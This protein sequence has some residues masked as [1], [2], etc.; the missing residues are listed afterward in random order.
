MAE[1]VANL[2]R[3]VPEKGLP[4]MKRTKLILVGGFLGT[5]KT[6]LLCQAAHQLTQQGHRVAV[7]T[8]D[9][10]PGLV[11]TLIFKQAGWTVGEIAGGCFCCK[12]DDLVETANDLIQAANPDILIAEPVGSCTDLSATVLQPFKDILAP[13]FEL[14]PFT[15]LIDPNRLLDVIAKSPLSPLHS[16]ARYILR[17]Q[18][19][20]ADILV[21]NKADQ[22]PLPDFQK[23]Q[24]ELGKQFPHTPL[25]SMS[26]LHGQGVPQWLEAVMQP[27]TLVGQKLAEVDYDTYAEGEAVLGWLNVTAS[28]SPRERLDWGS[29]SNGFLE[30]LQRI[31]TNKSAEIAHIKM[32]VISAGNQSLSASLTSSQGKV[33]IR[34]QMYGDS[35]VTLVLNA[36]VQLPSEELLAAIEE[37]LKTACGA[38]IQ[39][40]VS[41]I[42]SLSP[43][44]PQPLHRYAT[45]I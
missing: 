40:R 43:G 42:Q 14:A 23:L 38:I 27:G 36:R 16:S 41:A 32:L 11:D 2:R 25:L 6:T 39:L 4:T 34:G 10:A 18:L 21:L 30:S 45:V 20:E 17:K 15:V 12:F 33:T 8:N 24:D 35:R 5:G 19:E 9:Q 22:L 29:W 26:A 28:A 3:I 13:Q 37:H 1:V 31:L 44:R 7:I